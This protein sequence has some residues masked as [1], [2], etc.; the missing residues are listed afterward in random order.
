MISLLGY[1]DA[2]KQELVA[3]GYRYFKFVDTNARLGDLFPL[4]CIV[5][6]KTNESFCKTTKTFYFA[7]P[8]TNLVG[9]WTYDSLIEHYR[10]ITL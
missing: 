4:V 9:P 1:V 8:E 6:R 2:L 5:A 7:L 10:N 3:R